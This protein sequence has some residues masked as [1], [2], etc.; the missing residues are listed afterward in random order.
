MLRGPVRDL[1]FSDK[2]SLNAG[3]GAQGKFGK[4]S[5]ILLC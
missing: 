1:L 2:F 3:S 5:Q 4:D